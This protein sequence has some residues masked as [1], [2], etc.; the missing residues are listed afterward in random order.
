MSN[1]KKDKDGEEERK[2]NWEGGGWG[3][4]IIYAGM[5]RPVE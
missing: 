1:E 2:T 3:C 5:A 4:C